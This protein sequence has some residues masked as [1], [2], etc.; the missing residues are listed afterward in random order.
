MEIRTAIMSKNELLAL[1]GMVSS[2]EGASITTIDPRRDHPMVK[3]YEPWLVTD[4]FKKVLRLSL[5]NGWSV[6][7]EGQPLWG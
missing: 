4:E 3:T 2:D 5:K 7:Y 1:V 6:I